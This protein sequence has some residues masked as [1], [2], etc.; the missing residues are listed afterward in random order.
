MKKE[1]FP[2]RTVNFPVIADKDRKISQKYGMIHPLESKT[3]TVRSVFIID[4][5]AKI[6]ALLFYPISIG[7]SFNE[8]KR[9]L[10]AIQISDAEEV[11]TPADWQPGKPTISKEKALKIYCQIKQIRWLNYFSCATAHLRPFHTHA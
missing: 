9:L 11:A 5:K 10:A 1:G 2:R 3:Q 6:R 8:V 7:R 4:P